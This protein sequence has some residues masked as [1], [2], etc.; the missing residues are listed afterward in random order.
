MARRGRRALRDRRRWLDDLARTVRAGYPDRPADRPRELARFIAACPSFRA[1]AHDPRRPLRVHVWT[2]APVE[3]GRSPWPVPAIPDLAALAAWLGLTQGHLA[4]FADC[5]SLER[6]VE[7]ERLRHYRRRW[8]RKSD[9][10][11]RLLEAPKPPL[12]DLQR[13]VLHGILDH[14]PPHDATHGFRLGRSVHTGAARHHGREVV[15]RIDLESF[16]T[17]IVAGRV[18]GT[19][20]LAGYPEPVAHTLAGLCTTVTPHS[21]VLAAPPTGASHTDRRRRLLH[22]VRT[23]HL[24]QGSPTSPALANLCAFGLDRR[25]TGLAAELGAAYTRYADDLVLSGDRHLACPSASRSVVRLVTRIAREEGF[26][27]HQDKT[28]VRTAAQR[29]CVTGLVVNER[30]NVPRPST[31]S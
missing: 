5:R 9:G 8:V 29:Q 18:F 15:V 21:V 20:R 23:P 11:L 24:A 6:G 2:V 1:A 22:A 19:F 25:L 31:T 16:F 26:R 30:A 12:K 27:V 17:S 14:I 10:S 7:D 13:R 3:M 4:W 28:R